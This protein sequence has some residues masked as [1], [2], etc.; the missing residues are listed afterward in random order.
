MRTFT[1][2]ELS[3]ILKKHQM[4]LNGDAEG[5]C[6]NFENANFRNA[7][8]R[9]ADFT[10][11]NFRNAD[12]T[13]AD[14]RNANFENANFRNA[15]FRNAN[16]ENAKLPAFQICPEKGSFTA[17]KK[18]M[19]GHTP[20]I[21]ELRIPVTAQRTGTLVG[22]KC[23]ADKVKVIAATTLDGSATPRTIFNSKYDKWFTYTVGNVAKADT[24]D[25]DIRIECT[26]GIH[27]FMTRQEAVDY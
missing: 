19:L 8:F 18:V 26:N 20:Y 1:A 3:A 13:N 6:A 4:Y 14:F 22:R 21:L 25:N 9:Y 16:F 17:F 7:N 12:F 24:F 2:E 11:A 5:E 10:N 23:R 27:F 15:N